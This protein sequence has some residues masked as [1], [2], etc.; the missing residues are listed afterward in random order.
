VISRSGEVIFDYELLYLI[1]ITFSCTDV[2][3]D[4]D[5]ENVVMSGM[6]R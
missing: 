1:Y 5:Y 6:P 2:D 4:D 3:E